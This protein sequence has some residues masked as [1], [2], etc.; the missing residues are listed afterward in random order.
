MAAVSAMEEPQKRS[1]RSVATPQARSVPFLPEALLIDVFDWFGKKNRAEGVARSYAHLFSVDR[2]WYRCA[3]SALWR[4]FGQDF[5][6]MVHSISPSLSSLQAAR[7]LHEWREVPTS[8]DLEP[9]LVAG[10]VAQKFGA[11]WASCFS[12][13]TAKKVVRWKRAP[14]AAYNESDDSEYDAKWEDFC[15]S[16]GPII[17]KRCEL[18]GGYGKCTHEIYA[19]LSRDG[20][21]VEVQALMEYDVEERNVCDFHEG[22]FTI[23]ANKRVNGK[24]AA[25]TCLFEWEVRDMDDVQELHLNSRE[26]VAFTTFF[27]RGSTQECILDLTAMLKSIFLGVNGPCDYAPPWSNHFK[28]IAGE[29]EGHAEDETRSESQAD[30]SREAEDSTDN[31]D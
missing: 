25:R 17:T 13:R 3:E 15:E 9:A 31:D 18:T 5:Q 21:L 16:P 20:E 4:S 26:A 27:K 1:K 14:E 28:S 30:D 7:R 19:A 29:L 6:Q 12:F 24:T 10:L 23:R 11:A 2:T 8:I 22:Q